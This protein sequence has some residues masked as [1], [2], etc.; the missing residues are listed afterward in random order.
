MRRLAIPVLLA[1]IVL[2]APPATVVA[3]HRGLDGRPPTPFG[4]F[5]ER[6]HGWVAAWVEDPTITIHQGVKASR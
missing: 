4:E 3:D 5:V 1:S 6:A 2:A